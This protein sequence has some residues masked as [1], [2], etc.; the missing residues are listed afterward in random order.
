M[1]WYSPALR[2][3]SICILR[4]LLLA[5]AA[6]KEHSRSGLGRGHGGQQPRE[7]GQEGRRSRQ[8]GAEAGCCQAGGQERQ[9]CCC[10]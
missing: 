2:P 4:S 3:T 5:E 7:A 6:A 10:C 9:G 8:A 1:T